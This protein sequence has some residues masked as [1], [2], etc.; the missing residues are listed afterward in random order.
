VQVRPYAAE[1]SAAITEAEQAQITAGN[2]IGRSHL[3]AVPS[4]DEEGQS[5]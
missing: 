4:V 2:P 5:A 3:H 1:V